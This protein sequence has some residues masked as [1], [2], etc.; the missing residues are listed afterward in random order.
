MKIL[1]STNWTRYTLEFNFHSF[2]K[3]DIPQS[4]IFQRVYTLGQKDWAHSV[5]SYVMYR[6]V[7]T[8]RRL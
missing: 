7:E 4:K 3:Y 8:T 2:S 1:L 5:S 6:K